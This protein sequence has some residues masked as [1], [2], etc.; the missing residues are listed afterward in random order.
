M[1][2]VEYQWADGSG[3]AEVF[4]HSAVGGTGLVGP[5]GL[6]PVFFLARLRRPMPV[7]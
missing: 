3:P 7:C 5:A 2:T 6:L 4:L 1:L